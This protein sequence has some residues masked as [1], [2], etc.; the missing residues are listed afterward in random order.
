MISCVFVSANRCLTD[1]RCVD[2]SKK[3][4]FIFRIIAAEAF[5]SKA[6][7]F[8][9]VFGGVGWRRVFRVIELNIQMV[10]ERVP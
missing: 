9:V 2:L 6:H 7:E 4:S 5:L 1:T 10:N 3:N 8:T